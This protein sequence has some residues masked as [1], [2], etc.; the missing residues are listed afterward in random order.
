[1]FRPKTVEYFRGKGMIVS[2]SK[3]LHRGASFDNAMVMKIAAAHGVS[4]AQVF[5]RW[6][7]QK[8]LVVVSKTGLA[9]RMY[10]NRDVLWFT[11]S[12]AE[13]K[14]LDSMTT[15]EAVITREEL[16]QTRKQSM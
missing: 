1:M 8:G 3:A 9:E 6:G 12:E 4:P 5:L 14:Q 13:M 7:V 16:E 15:E 10:E 2:A 11:L